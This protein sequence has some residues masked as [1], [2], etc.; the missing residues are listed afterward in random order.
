M[1]LI[2]DSGSTKTDWLLLKNTNSTFLS[3]GGINPYYMSSEHIFNMLAQELQPLIPNSEIEHIFFYGSG[4]STDSKCQKIRDIL[5]KICPNARIE[6]NHDMLAAARSLCQDKPGIACILGTGS[7]SCVYDGNN[8][9]RQMVSLG[10]FFGDEGS[11]THL[12]KLLITDYLKGE[13]PSNISNMLEKQFNLSL[14][15]VLDNIYNHNNPNKFLASFSPFI[16]QH[17]NDTYIRMLIAKSFE[18]FLEVGVKKFSGFEHLEA[19]FVGSVAY[20]FQDILL[21]V[22]KKNNIKIG[23]VQK[24]VIEGLRTYH[25]LIGQN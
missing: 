3:T 14:E 6:V 11:G 2:A 5:S 18:S 22:A 1:I 8:I 24:S 10:Y 7:N 17:S 16:Q 15:F 20:Y 9:T 19:N 23:K 13:T 21:D 4:C 25:L 12:G